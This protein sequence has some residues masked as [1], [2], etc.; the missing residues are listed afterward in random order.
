[1][2]NNMFMSAGIHFLALALMFLFQN[3]NAT[4]QSV[5][6]ALNGKWVIES[7][8]D[9]IT[10]GYLIFQPGSTYEFS[11]RYPDGTGAGIKGG[12]EFKKEGS[13]GKLRLCL[14]DCSAAGSD[15]TSSFALVRLAD[16]GS[17]EIYFSSDGNYP[18]KFPKAKKEKG[19]YVFIRE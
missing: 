5:E 9:E 16:E 10:G 19:M 15:W 6:E 3:I 11:K 17:L 13:I 1:M 8:G 2:K 14:G 7:T 4:A 12:Y 18:K